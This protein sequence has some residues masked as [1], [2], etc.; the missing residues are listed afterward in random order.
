MTTKEFQLFSDQTTY[1]KTILRPICQWI[2]YRWRLAEC[3]TPDS[4]ICLM[5]IKQNTVG[6]QRNDWLI[7]GQSRL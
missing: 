1:I 3:Q 2:L 4:L 5:I 6:I 7:G